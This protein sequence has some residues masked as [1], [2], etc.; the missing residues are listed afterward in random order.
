MKTD[1]YLTLCLE[2]AAKS[3]LH[4]R[5]G[6]II[7]RGGKVIGQGHNDY[8]P[9]YDGGALKHGRIA[10]GTLHGPAIASLK[11]KLKKQKDKPKER[12]QQ[13]RTSPTP[14]RAHF[15]PLRK[16][17]RRSSRQ[18]P[19]LHALRD[20]GHPQ[21]PLHLFNPVLDGV[22]RDYA[23]SC[24]PPTSTPSARPAPA[25][26]GSR[27]KSVVLKLPHLDQT[28]RERGRCNDNKGER[29]DDTNGE[30]EEELRE[31]KEK[32]RAFHGHVGGEKHHQKGK[33]KGTKKGGRNQNGCQYEGYGRCGQQIQ[34][35]AV[36]QVSASSGSAEYVIRGYDQ[37]GYGIEGMTAPAK[38]VKQYGKAEKDYKRS[39]K[40]R[41]KL[42]ETGQPAPLLLPKGNTGTTSSSVNDR[43]KSPRL[44]GADIYVTRL[45]W[46]KGPA[47][48]PRTRAAPAVA[49][50]EAH[51]SPTD[52]E[53]LSS[54]TSSLTSGS[55]HDELINRDPS[56]SPS[57][58]PKPADTA[59]NTQ[60]VRASRP[61]YRCISYMH[62]VG[63]KRVFWTNDAGEW[64]GGKVR[65][66]VDALDCSMES[67]AAGEGDKGGP[68][69]NGVF[70]TK[71]EV[72]MLKRMMGQ[73]GG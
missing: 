60:L 10:K 70:V 36:Q 55:L 64:E 2:Q 41:P 17:R 24:S 57:T 28:V 37:Q 42:D 9:G 51:P 43:K 59:G 22:L 44:K 56:P 71:H 20:D 4:Y 52:S 69:G 40:M 50:V 15:H 7:V 1:N 8:R 18:H 34:Q 73:Q 19:A 65:D 38:L 67:V 32:G 23:A 13:Y 5:H 72:L 6:A 30:D 16:L 39:G 45:G 33:R 3:P 12:Q 25:P 58:Q 68:M 14:P 35:D 31:L 29:G 47:Q 62:S 61:C 46:C 48:T 54:S 63:I 66:L 27:F 21:R 11:E 26:A 49:P 53:D